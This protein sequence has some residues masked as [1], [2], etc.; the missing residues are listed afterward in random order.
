MASLLK[1]PPVND[2]LARLLTWSLA[3][4]ILGWLLPK[5]F[6]YLSCGLLQ[7]I[8]SNVLVTWQLASPKSER[9]KR[10]YK[11]IPDG[12]HILLIAKY[13]QSHSIPSAV[14]YSLEVQTICKTEKIL[15]VVNIK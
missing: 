10:E 7:N 4:R 3:V 1:A 6:S 9:F 12:N 2:P 14:S 15:D 5:D 11:P 8:L 13:C